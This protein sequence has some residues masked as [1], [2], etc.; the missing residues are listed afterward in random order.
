MTTFYPFIPMLHSLQNRVFGCSAF[1][2]VHSSYQ[3]KLDPRIIKSVFIG[4]APQQKG[5]QMLSPSK[6]Y[7]YVSKNV[8]FHEI[9]S[10]FPSSQ[11]QRG[12]YSRN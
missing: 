10:F 8:I 1:V 6:S 3:G 5:V 11:L 9:D 7:V 2:H 12:E 4:Y